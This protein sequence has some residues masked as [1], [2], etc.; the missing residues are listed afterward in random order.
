MVEDIVMKGKISE[1]S[2]REI[3]IGLIGTKALKRNLVLLLTAKKNQVDGVKKDQLS[4]IWGIEMKTMTK[5]QLKVD[6][7]FKIEALTSSEETHHRKNPF[8]GKQL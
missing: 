1:R 2:H 4:F 3:I 6:H 8:R 7:H 5:D